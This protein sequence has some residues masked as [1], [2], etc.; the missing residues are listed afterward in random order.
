MTFN[1][2]K[3]KFGKDLKSNNNRPFF[4]E[5]AYK[6]NKRQERGQSFMQDNMKIHNRLSN[7]VN[8][9]SKEEIIKKL[10]E[11]KIGL[12]N[13]GGSCYMASVIQILI[14]SK[15]FLEQFYNNK[16]FNNSR[17][18]S[19][20]FKNFIEKIA[21]FVGTQ[22]YS[23]YI[24]NF[25][26]EYNKINNK[27]RGD[28]GNNPMTFFTEFIKK[29]SEETNDN[30]LNLFMG[31]RY[32]KFEGM[33]DLNYK[34]DFIFLLM[35]LN[36]KNKFIQDAI[37]EVKEIENNNNLKIIEEIIVKP[38]ILIINLE[39]DDHIQYKIE[40]WLKVYNTNYQLMAI[41]RYNDYH[42]TA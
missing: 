40:H 42:S 15:Q 25:A 26:N 5:E 28:K 39:F 18:L 41:N 29:L 3:S 21:N 32:I 33:S 4:K 30:I 27:F 1:Y 8:M 16:T 2:G 31:K 22:D 10:L 23:T 6:N 11:S 36:K 24:K 37:Y 19:Y 9:A 20:L 12:I 13:A 14:H 17:P 7:N 38:N 35:V 34:E